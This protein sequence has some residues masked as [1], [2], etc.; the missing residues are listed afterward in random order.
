MSSLQA[1]DLAITYLC[2]LH[3][4]AIDL[5]ARVLDK[6]PMCVENDQGHFTIAQHAQFVCLLH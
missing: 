6:L 5:R 2:V 1:I 3:Q 4:N